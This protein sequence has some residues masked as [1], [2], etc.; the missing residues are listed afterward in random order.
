[1]VWN[2]KEGGSKS[3][4]KWR[5]AA[6]STFQHTLSYHILDPLWSSIKQHSQNFLPQHWNARSWILLEAFVLNRLTLHCTS[7]C[8]TRQLTNMESFKREHVQV[9]WFVS[10]FIMA[11]I[12]C[13]ANMEE[14]LQA[15]V[16]SDNEKF[17]KD[18]EGYFHTY[19]FS[20]PTSPP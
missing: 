12:K 18:I 8:L 15:C 16:S 11:L 2:R 14:L 7:Q 3:I 19:K 6:F 9:L 4:R 1:M 5:E 20:I 13:S 17:N 10:H